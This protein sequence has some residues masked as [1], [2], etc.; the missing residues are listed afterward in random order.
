[1]QN[2]LDI[3]LLRADAHRCYMTDVSMNGRRLEMRM[4][5]HAL[6]DTSKIPGLIN[7]YAGRL[8]FL[9]GT[10]PRFTCMMTLAET[11]T[12]EDT[13]ACA[14]ELVRDIAQTLT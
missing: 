12:P 13:L 1:M 6:V 5:P 7:A 10:E 3:A 14:K 11:K 4:F 2:L 9:P 8:R